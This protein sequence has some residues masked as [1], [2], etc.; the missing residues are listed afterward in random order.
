M[1]SIIALFISATF[2][3]TIAPSS[4]FSS[5]AFIFRDNLSIDQHA[6]RFN[7]IGKQAFFLQINQIDRL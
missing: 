1:L 7:H 4:I 6:I 5:S 3:P 2:K